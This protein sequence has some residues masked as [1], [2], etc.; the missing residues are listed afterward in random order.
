VHE[1]R[2]R[3]NAAVFHFHLEPEDMELINSLDTGK[4]GGLS[5]DEVTIQRFD[6]KIPD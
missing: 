6:F 2:I 5:P 4:R 3:E 1:A